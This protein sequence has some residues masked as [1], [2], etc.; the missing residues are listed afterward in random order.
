[1]SQDRWRAMPCKEEENKR[2]ET[3]EKRPFALSERQY[4]F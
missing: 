1:M 4:N 3:S 2:S